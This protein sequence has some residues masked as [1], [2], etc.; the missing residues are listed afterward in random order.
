MLKSLRSRNIALLVGVLLLGELLTMI[1][2]AV[3]VIRPQAERV[4]TILAHNVAV[5]SATLDELPPDRRARLIDRINAAGSIR[6]LQASS[7][8]PEDRGVPT[9]LERVVLQ[10]FVREMR[11]RDAVLW[12][13]GRGGQLWARVR[14]GE[15]FY[16]ISYDRPSGWTPTGALAASVAVAVLLA[17]LAGL[18]LQRRLGAPLKDLASA[19]DAVHGDAVPTPLTID[20]PTEIATVAQS[21]N[22]MIARLST[23]AANRA[24][25]LAGISHDLRTPLAKIRL[26]LALIP[27][28][29]A[30]MET[31]LTR[32]LD[33]IDAMLT[34]FLDFARGVDDETEAVV[35]LVQEV[36]AAIDDLA[37]SV[38]IEVTSSL[39]HV[40]ACVRPVA[41]RRAIINLVRNAMIHGKPPV[42]V[43]VSI[44]GS[45][46]AIAVRDHGGGIP[47]SQLR[48]IDQ[49]FVRGD[50]ARGASG[51][52]GLGLAI[53][54]H[55]AAAHGGSLTL[56]NVDDGG[57]VQIISLQAWRGRS[58]RPEL[59]EIRDACVHS[60]VVDALSRCAASVAAQVK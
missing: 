27:Q 46:A 18:A 24:F 47:E 1:L 12:H 48:T 10:A 4:A 52:A 3:L 23:D 13:G 44:A 51:G 58:S 35:D 11:Q 31:M 45:K 53:A 29:D 50:A 19:A 22:S 36:R 56:H 6:I 15:T 8:P 9:L 42:S 55:V 43:E 7:P 54:R 20:G 30:E 41:L 16:W 21:F 39:D 14:L 32:Q 17:L 2:V 57:L 38:A 26:S 60:P 59:R 5:V 33:R 37:P 28:I 49:P 25:M 40:R 34:Q